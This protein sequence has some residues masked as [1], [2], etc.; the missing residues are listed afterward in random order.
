VES[1]AAVA[2]TSTFSGK[3]RTVVVL[4][5][6]N[7]TDPKLMPDLS[8]SVDIE[9]ERQPNALVAP[10]DTVIKENGKNFVMVKTGS[11]YDRR[12]VKLGAANDAEQ[13]IASG[14]EKGAELLR[15]PS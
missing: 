10:R 11:G 6:I 4:F 5:T 2:Q 7:G 9:V 8:A 12:E 13:V 3:A 14:V 15:N 1:I